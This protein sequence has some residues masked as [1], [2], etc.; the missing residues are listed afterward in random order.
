[1]KQSDENFFEDNEE[2][3]NLSYPRKMSN[4]SNISDF[5]RDNVKLNFL[6]GIEYM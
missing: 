6:F 2:S 3:D 5:L 4:I 1:M